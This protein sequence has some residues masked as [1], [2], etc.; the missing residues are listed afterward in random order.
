MTEV[1]MELI[2]F[3]KSTVSRSDGYVN[4]NIAS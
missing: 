1:D 3:M 2:P 4:Y